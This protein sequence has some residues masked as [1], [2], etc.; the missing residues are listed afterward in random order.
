MTAIV[1]ATLAANLGLI[2]VDVTGPAAVVV[3]GPV[4]PHAETLAGSA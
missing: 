3:Q 4:A 2:A 1:G